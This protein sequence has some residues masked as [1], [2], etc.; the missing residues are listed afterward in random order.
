MFFTPV[1]AVDNSRQQ[2]RV[3]VQFWFLIVFPSVNIFQ[4]LVLLVGF[5]SYPVFGPRDYTRCCVG[6]CSNVPAIGLARLV[7]VRRL[8]IFCFRILLFFFHQLG[9]ASLS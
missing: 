9:F 5:S 1:A 2:P 4:D 8:Q 7:F 3:R 6:I